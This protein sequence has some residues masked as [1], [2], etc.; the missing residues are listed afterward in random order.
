MAEADRRAWVPPDKLASGLARRTEAPSVPHFRS[1]GRPR[2]PGRMLQSLARSPRAKQLGTALA[3]VRAVCFGAGEGLAQMRAV[4]F[5]TG[6]GCQGAK[7][8]KYGVVRPRQLALLLAFPG[9]AVSRFNLRALSLSDWH[10]LSYFF[11]KVRC[12][13][14]GQKLGYTMTA[15]L[16]IGAV[17]LAAGRFGANVAQ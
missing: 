13:D 9:Q 11:S 15:R 10:C 4:C 6:E 5:G 2:S 16:A 14:E 17:A 8:G 7:G 1:P 12:T 3:Q